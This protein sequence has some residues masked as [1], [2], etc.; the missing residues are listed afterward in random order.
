MAS[1]AWV[2]QFA[3]LQRLA[4]CELRAWTLGL[5]SLSSPYPLP[6]SGLRS[7]IGI[8]SVM[9]VCMVRGSGPGTWPWG[10]C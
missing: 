5:E 2:T 3:Q 8:F 1:S 4:R 6:I 10:G 7:L 9:S